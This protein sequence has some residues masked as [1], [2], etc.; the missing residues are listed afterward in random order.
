MIESLT[1]GPGVGV[2]DRPAVYAANALVGEGFADRLSSRFLLLIRKW[3]RSA[4]GPVAA[5]GKG[6]E[7]E[8]AI[9]QE[10]LGAIE[11]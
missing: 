5:L 9:L 6:E 2:I 11:R 8:Q 7:P 3:R 1:E 10:G 4:E